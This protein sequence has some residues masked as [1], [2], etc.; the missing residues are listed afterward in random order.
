[1]NLVMSITELSD[2]LK[3]SESSLY[4]LARDGRLP[5]QKVGKHW[6]FSKEAIDAWLKGKALQENQ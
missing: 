5:A 6:R 3:V 2:Y 4:K 1:M